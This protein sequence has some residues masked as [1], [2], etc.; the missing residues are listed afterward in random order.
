VS[1]KRY[2]QQREMLRQAARTVVTFGQVE[3]VTHLAV[4]QARDRQ[5]GV[6]LGSLPATCARRRRGWGWWSSGSMRRIPPEP[7]V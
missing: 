1:A 5:T 6:S 2:R 4:G 7:V 3:G